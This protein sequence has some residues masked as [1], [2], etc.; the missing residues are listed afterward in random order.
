[1]LLFWPPPQRSAS[2][3][4]GMEK[5][6]IAVNILAGLIYKNSIMQSVII[7]YDDLL[8]QL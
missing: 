8:S 6:V 4:W 7:N 3:E 2:W 5:Y 1:M